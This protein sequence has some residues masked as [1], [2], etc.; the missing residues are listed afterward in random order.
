MVYFVA[1]QAMSN[2]KYMI[3]VNVP[4][5][6]IEYC[7]GSLNILAARI[8]NLSYASY[9]RMCRDLY[10]AEIY[11]KN[12]VYCVAYFNNYEDVKPLLDELNKRT[13]FILKEIKDEF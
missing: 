9:L 7:K 5:L 6:P 8:M 10:G 12:H 11:G 13:E 3:K 4:N 1:E 2:N